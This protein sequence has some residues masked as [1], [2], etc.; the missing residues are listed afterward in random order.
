MSHYIP[1]SR[2]KPDIQITTARSGGPGGQHVN[3]V[4]TKVILRF[5][6]LESGH[7]TEEE[8]SRL[9][10]KIG[11]QLTSDGSLIITA[12]SHKSQLKNKELAF[13]KLDRILT[14]ASFVPKPR[15]KT[16]PSKSAINKRIKAKKEHSEKKKWR[17]KI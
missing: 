10:E 6:V 11:S 4:E 2:I 14:K 16:K 17:G 5:N 13:K 1:I 12:D 15:K 3:K 7:L 8:K 9:K